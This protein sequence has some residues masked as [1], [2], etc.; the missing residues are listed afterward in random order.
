MDLNIGVQGREFALLRCE[1]FGVE[2]AEV[3]CKGAV[4]GELVG[5]CAA[6]AEGGVG[7][8]RKDRDMLDTEDDSDIKVKRTEGK[9]T[10]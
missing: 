5:G 3:D 8:C 9:H 10:K 7:A 2:I 4:V 1:E 6:D